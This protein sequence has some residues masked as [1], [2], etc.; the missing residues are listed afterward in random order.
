MRRHDQQ[1]RYDP[2]QLNAHIPFFFPVSAPICICPPFQ[3]CLSVS[4]RPLFRICLVRVCPVHVCFWYQA[5]APALPDPPYLLR[6]IRPVVSPSLSTPAVANAPVSAQCLV[7]ARIPQRMR[8]VQA[9]HFFLLCII[10]FLKIRIIP[11][12]RK[13]R[14]HAVT[15]FF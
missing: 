7:I 13:I 4:T 5:F 11:E 12:L 6:Y 15:Q 2:K 9:D 14:V 8:H 3:I 1:H 10:H